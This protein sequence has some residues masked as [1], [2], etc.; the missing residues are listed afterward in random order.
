MGHPIVVEDATFEEE[1]IT[2][3]F[4]EQV[5]LTGSIPNIIKESFNVL[6]EEGYNPEVA[7][8]VC[9]YEVKNIVESFH[10]KGFEFLNDSI[11]NLA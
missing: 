6:L 11:S 2:D 10:D 4:G 5:I 1:V 9:Y 8:L 7:W 3:I